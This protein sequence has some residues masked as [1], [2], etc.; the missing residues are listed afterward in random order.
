MYGEERSREGGGMYTDA[1][2]GYRPDG[3]TRR[4]TEIGGDWNEAEDWTRQ[5]TRRGGGRMSGP[6]DP[7]AFAVHHAGV[8]QPR[9]R[10]GSAW[11]HTS[12]LRSSA[13]YARALRGDGE[14]EVKWRQMT[15]RTSMPAR[16]ALKPALTRLVGREERQEQREL[17]AREAAYAASTVRRAVEARS[18][19]EPS[20]YSR[21][22][23]HT[24]RIREQK[25]RVGES[26]ERET[27]RTRRTPK[28]P[29]NETREIKGE[30]HPEDLRPS[31]FH[32]SSS[33]SASLDSQKRVREG[34]DEGDY[35]GRLVSEEVVSQGLHSIQGKRR[36]GVG[37]QESPTG[38]LGTTRGATEKRNAHDGRDAQTSVLRV[39]SSNHGARRSSSAGS[40]PRDGVGVSFS[41]VCLT[42]V[43]PSLHPPPQRS[44]HRKS[45]APPPS[46]S[47]GVRPRCSGPRATSSRSPVT[48]ARSA[49][50]RRAFFARAGE[51]GGHA[52]C[53]EC[54]R[55]E[56]RKLELRV[57]GGGLR[58]EGPRESE[59]FGCG[60]KQVTSIWTLLLTP[61]FAYI[62]AGTLGDWDASDFERSV[63]VVSPLVR[64]AVVP[65]SPSPGSLKLQTFGSI[66]DQSSQ[67]STI[68][69]NY[70]SIQRYIQ[71]RTSS[72]FG[73]SSFAP[74]FRDKPN[75][76][77]SNQTAVQARHLSHDI[78]T[79]LRGQ[80]Q[81]HTT[82]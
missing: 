64:V 37:G 43:P 63:S 18:V 11:T 21:T 53:E 13:L 70:L 3:G 72:Y 67:H 36:R 75:S 27:R 23:E 32:A 48:K 33:L 54:E 39:G 5:R 20:R 44:Q 26:R 17:L 52:L 15:V 41:K 34:A 14:E 66:G 82:P 49:P 76:I 24:W 10:L 19:A 12:A 65:P 56:K 80:F 29:M 69:L 6:S 42:L 57:G 46:A 60:D 9:I 47:P 51:A 68:H 50:P 30:E 71:H 35:E 22:C 59:G 16:S 55:E 81:F 79:D 73:S 74:P 4:D 40:T 1:A 77:H 2:Y 78:V 28:K 38:T 62:V 31:S 61:M 7:L 45:H 58:E 8:E 25:K